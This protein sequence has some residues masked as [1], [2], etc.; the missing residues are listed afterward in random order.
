MSL[1]IEDESTNKL[2]LDYESLA[3]T[4]YEAALTY[5]N[6]PYEAEVNLILTTDAAIREVNKEFRQ[7]D[8]ATD[9]LSFP[10]IEFSTAG[11][12]AQVEEEFA[13][14]FNPDSGEL[15]LG[16][17]MLS[18]DRVIAQ[19]KEYGH[20]LEREY[21]FL[22]VHSMLHLFGYDHIEEIERFEMEEKQRQLMAIIEQ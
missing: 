3:I 20:S 1:F 11:D 6:C 22:L 19:A 15:L 10:M 5:V 21:T 8:K 16:E 7:I 4:V 14:N 12:F 17:I 9:V 2:S 18:T 13:D